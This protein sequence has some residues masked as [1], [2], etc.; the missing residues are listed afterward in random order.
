MR[1]SMLA[2]IFLTLQIL[3]SFG[4]LHRGELFAT[5]QEQNASIPTIG[6]LVNLDQ[7]EGEFVGYIPSSHQEELVFATPE[8]LGEEQVFQRRR[9]MLPRLRQASHHPYTIYRQ[10]E[11]VFSYLPGNGEDLG[12][13]DFESSHYLSSDRSSGFSTGIGIHLLSGPKVVDAPPRLYNFNFGYQRRGSIGDALSFDVAT[14]IGIYS[15][16]EGSARE[17]VRF[18]SHAVGMLHASPETDWVFGIDYL[19][20]GDLKILPVFGFSRHSDR[21][22]SMRFDLIFPRP[23]VELAFRS[24]NVLYVAGR[25]GGDS[26]D[27]E[28]PD[29][30]EDVMTYRD[31]RLLLGLKR[32]TFGTT[33]I[34]EIGYA[35]GRQM[36]F[37][38]DPGIAEPGGA[39]LLRFVTSR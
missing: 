29:E 38:S 17:G 23:Q 13:I 21:H 16:F 26:W 34:M 32:D 27:M 9:M 36:E 1:I 10:E 14:S 33:R 2:S 12:M 31:Y 28:F 8:S 19:D 30:T 22:P 18:P 24:G 5:E 7:P 35:F 37:K 15:D 39:F 11:S 4:F 25:L 3:N 6:K 20:R